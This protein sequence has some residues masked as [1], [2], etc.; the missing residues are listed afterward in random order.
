MVGEIKFT[1][2]EF[3]YP[4]RPDVPVLNGLS[5]TVESGQTT[6]IVGSSGCGKV[7]I[8][9][10]HNILKSILLSLSEHMCAIITAIL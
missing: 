10:D 7:N 8:I 9:A 2:V 4:S 5:F 6:A 1:N 3:C